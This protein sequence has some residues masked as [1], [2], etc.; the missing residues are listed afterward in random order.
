MAGET[1]MRWLPKTLG[2]GLLLAVLLPIS[3]AAP[4]ADV[5][6]PQAR[7]GR[8]VLGYYGP[9]DPNSWTSLPANAAQI[10]FLAGHWLTIDAC[11]NLTT[12]DDQTLKQFAR[13]NGIRIFPSLLTLS[14]WL[15][16]R[17]LTDATVRA[18]SIQQIVEYVM[19]EGYDGFDLD[20]E[21]VEAADR[22]AYT[23]YV[24]AL[25]AALHERGR[26]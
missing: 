17:L 15:N 24:A 7:P 10:D 3:A 18:Q 16:H 12:R 1:D 8:Q 9:G 4:P 25:G 6:A 5:P 19:A 13:A 2:L 11:G 14:G 23:A 20:I 26:V 21:A 22:D